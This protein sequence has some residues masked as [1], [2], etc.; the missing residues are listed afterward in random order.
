[1]ISELLANTGERAP[2]IERPERLQFFDRRLVDDHLI[3]HVS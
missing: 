1:M 3:S 2:L